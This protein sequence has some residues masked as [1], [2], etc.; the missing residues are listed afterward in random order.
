MQQVQSHRLRGEGSLRQA[1]SMALFEVKAFGRL[2]LKYNGLVV[3]TFPTRKAQEL[4]AFLLLNQGVPHSRDKLVELLWPGAPAENGRA[5]LSTTLWRIRVLLDQFGLPPDS[6]IES[7]S[8]AVMLETNPP[9][10]IDVC[11]FEDY[12][13]AA[14][15][16]PEEEGEESLLQAAHAL[17]SGDLLEGLYCPFLR[18]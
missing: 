16:A 17:Y 15:L 1:D 3:S 10:V 8:E 14:E 7:S 12:L 11:L 2:Q 18:R 13:E 4:L 5:R 6:W 9:A